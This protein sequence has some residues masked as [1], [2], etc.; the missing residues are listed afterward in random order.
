[1][2]ILNCPVG[3]CIKRGSIKEQESRGLLSSLAFKIPLSEVPIF[4]S[5]LFWG[6]K[7]NKIIN[8]F[9]LVGGKFI[10]KIHLRQS[11]F[12]YSACEPYIKNKERIK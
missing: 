4:G 9:L 11:R 1:M 6:Y 3:N 12:T 2:V 10:P 5:I 7:M 8:K